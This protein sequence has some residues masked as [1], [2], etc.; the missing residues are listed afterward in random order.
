MNQ[1]NEVECLPEERQHHRVEEITGKGT[2]KVFPWLDDYLGT[3]GVEWAGP[4]RS[5]VVTVGSGPVAGCVTVQK[6]TRYC[7]YED[8]GKFFLKLLLVGN[9]VERVVQSCHGHYVL[10]AYSKRYR[11]LHPEATGN[12]RAESRSSEMYFEDEVWE[13]GHPLPKAWPTVSNTRRQS[14]KRNLHS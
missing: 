9:A 12:M 4:V 13:R 14:S 1:G 3:T 2:E 10:P 5:M 11:P 6:E 8:L 7:R